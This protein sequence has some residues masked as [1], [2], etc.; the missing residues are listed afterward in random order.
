MTW[1]SLLL[2]MPNVN[3]SKNVAADKRTERIRMMKASPEGKL[4]RSD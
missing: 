3:K 4:S 1:L 2:R